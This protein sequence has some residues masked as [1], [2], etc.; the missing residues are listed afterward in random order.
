MA[1]IRS[2]N[3]STRKYF[4][5]I[6]RLVGQAGHRAELACLLWIVA[7]LVTLCGPSKGQETPPPDKSGYSLFNP[8]PEQ[9][10]REM[11]PDRP[12]KTDS[13][14]TVDAGHFQIEM[15]FANFT[16]DIPSS[17]HGNIR[18]ESYQIA[19]M[20]LKVG[21][22]NNMDLQL[23]LSPW[24]WQR[25]EDRTTK[26]VELRSGFGDIT[27][28]VKINLVGNDGG[29]FALGLIP[30][31]KLPTNQD[32]LGNKAVEG[33]VGIP[34]ALDIPGWDVGFQTTFSFNHNDIGS[35]YHAEFDNSVSIGHPLIGKLSAYVEFFSSV[36]SE[37]GAGWIGTVD[38]WLTY[39]VNKNLRLDGGVYIG[40]TGAADDWHPW[41]GM[42]WRF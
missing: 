21:V 26:T 33:G 5:L 38:T 35:G 15:D 10:M 24:E 18:F 30:F 14:F 9:Y 42:T 19:P 20:N 6:D 40:V 4:G 22:L 25:I 29:F 3:N 8:T 13:P 31:V 28:R 32:H 16:Y 1:F 41:L 36:S 2:T 23:V 12:D 11:S 17:E 7:F 27:P 37:R 34:Y 39:Q